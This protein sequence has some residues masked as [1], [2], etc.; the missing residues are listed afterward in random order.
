MKIM[1]YDLEIVLIRMSNLDQTVMELLEAA[2]NDWKFFNKIRAK[3]M[4]KYGARYSLDKSMFD[5]KIGKMA[6]QGEK[7]M[8][9]GILGY[10]PTVLEGYHLHIL[11]YGE[12]PVASSIGIEDK[13]GRINFM[14]F[15]NINGLE[16]F[17]K[18]S[19]MSNLSSK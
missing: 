7:I 10:C 3:I 11:S 13:R 12:I 9:E 14:R 2:E 15:S 5:E 16:S 4:K 8:V 18:F 17:L 19:N 1:K 6:N